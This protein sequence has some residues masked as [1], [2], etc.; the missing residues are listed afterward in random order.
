M[1]K[2]LVL[3]IILF[4]I[5]LFS[6]TEIKLLR[7]P[8]ISPDN[9][10]VAFSFRGD[11][12]KVS[13]SGGDAV[14]L[15]DNIADDTMPVF[16]NNGKYIA[17]ASK[18]NGNY[19]V[20]VIPSDGGVPIQLTYRDSD[21]FPTDWTKDDKRI[22]F[23]TKRDIHFYYG[24]FSV[25][26]VSLNGGTPEPFIKELSRYGKLSKDN[27]YVAFNINYI[28]DLRKRYRGSANT[29][30]W[31]YDS[32]TNKYNKLTT[33]KGNDKW[34]VFSKDK[35]YFVSD[36]KDNVF[37]LWRMNIDGSNKEQVTFLKDQVRF[38]DVS[39][40]N[41]Y[42]IF[43]YKDGLYLKRGK[44][45][46][47]RIKVYAPIDYKTSLKIVKKYSSKAEE[48]TIDKKANFYAF[49]IRGELF[50]LK[51]DWK[52]AKNITN[53]YFREKDVCL[54]NDGK[55]LYF[56][57]DKNNNKDIYVAYSIDKNDLY[58]SFKIKTEQISNTSKEEH[59]PVLSNNN[60]KMC[61][62]EGNGNLVVMDLKTKKKEY[63]FKS[64]NVSKPVWS[65]DDNYI[66]FSNM[67]NNFNADIFI[68]SLKEKKYYNI[69]KHPDDDTDPVWS[70]DGKFLY[71]ISK[72]SNNNSDIWQVSLLK[73]WYDMTE[74]D[75][76]LYNEKNKN[77]KSKDKNE[78]KPV[79]NIDFNKIH[80]RLKHITSLL[81]DEYEIAISKDSKSIYF[82][83]KNDNGVG[84]YKVDW[85]GKNR[86]T[87][88]SSL[89]NPYN[90]I[91]R[92]KS[93]YLISGG[94]I[95]K[96]DG[97]KR[98]NIGFNARVVINRL[99]ENEEKF[100]EAWRQM[101]D[102][103]YDS[104]FHGINWDNMYDRY[105]PMAVN[106]VTPQDFDYVFRMML[107]EL[108]ASHLGI[109]S[110]DKN[111]SRSVKTGYLG[112]IFDFSY[113]GK[114]LKVKKVLI[115]SPAYRKISR[116]YENDIILSINGIWINKN[117][118]I[119]KLLEDKV[120]EKV[121]LKVLR[122]RKTLEIVITPS[123]SQRSYIYDT[124]VNENIKRVEELSNNEFAYLHIQ[125]MG[126][127]NLEKFEK[128]LYSIANGKKG[129]IIDV[130]Y[131]GGGWIT[132]YLL[133][134]LMTKQHAVTIPRDGGKG[135]PHTRRSIF[136]WS[137]PI[138]V[139]IN[140]QSYSNAE[141]F[142]WSIRTLKRGPLVG[143]QTFGAV[144]S[145]GGTSLIDGTWLRLPFRGWYV[146]DGTMTN[147]ENNGCPPDYP[148]ENLPGEEYKGI[149]KQLEKA[150]KVL[151]KLVLESEK[152]PIWKG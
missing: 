2:T 150:V 132:D 110:P 137:K 111:Y 39:D 73:K 65:P 66:A 117:T 90:L 139:L 106:T 141:I 104:H 55:R 1:K 93:L 144:I 45:D 10:F 105:K 148:V 18:R 26:S 130:R 44:E 91:F 15:T 38:F 143:K 133:Q 84:L 61:Y 52:R 33:F 147:M 34:P 4:T 122:K 29:D 54:S 3:I 32:R 57:S 128:E 75:W 114:G 126:W 48:L 100:N 118:N 119:Y 11:I 94:R 99:R 152:D 124:W 50:V 80:L 58:N 127:Q 98:K 136:S 7:Y 13:L 120:N 108:N 9:K 151:K 27:R 35:I 145:T 89:K 109:Y 21:D 51:K 96:I 81:G 22:I 92:N 64:W 17:F 146:N 20:Y 46:I 97:K 78:V 25:F 60:E 149:D 37:N 68:Y 138:V 42:I 140:Q 6:K 41:E 83:A 95:L 16:S 116:L 31:V 87:L 5:S 30:V 19:D 112:V 70:P 123:Y 40:N 131:N 8:T 113:K 47:K 135:Y 62:I 103:F 28:P 102:N 36:R 86:K 72:R 76:K 79:V 88:F 77:K 134:I 129:L 115:N 85:N 69:S 71:F 23:H 74:D 12:W 49:V 53:S 101:R 82:T 24:S 63:I 14:R 107:G 142:P 43:E 67:D 125:G 56:V 121:L 59:T